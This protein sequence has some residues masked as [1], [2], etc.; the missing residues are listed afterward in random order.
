MYE[1]QDCSSP[2]LRLYLLSSLTHFENFYLSS[3]SET[4][5]SDLKEALEDDHWEKNFNVLM[6]IV[7]R[8]GDSALQEIFYKRSVQLCQEGELKV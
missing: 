7:R 5:L 3:P 1:S 6:D 2:V 4:V 8:T